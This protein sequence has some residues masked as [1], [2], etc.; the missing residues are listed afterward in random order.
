MRWGLVGGTWPRN[1]KRREAGFAS[2]GR[3]P[4]ERTTE[5]QVDAHS[6]QPGDGLEHAMEVA[7][8][9]PDT[10]GKL[11]RDPIEGDT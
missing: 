9:T 11:L 3:R 10:A 7:R 8:T 5:R 4:L 6:G 1:W 2:A